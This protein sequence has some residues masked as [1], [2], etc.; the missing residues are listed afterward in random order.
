[1]FIKSADLIHFYI[2]SW[3]HVP[4]HYQYIFRISIT[5]RTNHLGFGSHQPWRPLQYHIG[6]VWSTGRWLLHVR[7]KKV[8]YTWR[9]VRFNARI[10]PHRVSALM[11]V[12]AHIDVHLYNLHQASA[13]YP[14]TSIDL[15][16]TLMLTHTHWRFVLLLWDKNP[17]KHPAASKR[18]LNSSSNRIQMMNANRCFTSFF[19]QPPPPPFHIHVTNLQKVMVTF[20]TNL[21]EYPK[22]EK[23]QLPRWL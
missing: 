20:H 11:L 9:F 4:G 22:P 19:V 18:E 15:V 8:H 6:D 12:M 16:S 17:N 10:Q 14:F 2:C 13:S 1:M 3:Q 7:N 5:W 21:L 23:I